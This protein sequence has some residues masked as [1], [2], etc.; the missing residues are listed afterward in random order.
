M[1]T[2]APMSAWTRFW[3]VPLRAERLALTR[4]LL[5]LAL[6]T[7]QLF[8]MLPRWGEFFGP[9]GS[10][11][12]GLHDAD[13]I[14]HWQWSVLFVSTDRPDVLWALFWVWVGVTALLV[15]G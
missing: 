1:T 9:E 11:F 13:S 15:V 6:L 2:P 5:G 3:H 4:V 14:R 12:N 7:N 10:A 8:E